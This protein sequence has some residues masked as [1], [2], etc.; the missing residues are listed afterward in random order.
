MIL[1]CYIK[2]KTQRA[3]KD[4]EYSNTDI[5]EIPYRSLT[6]QNSGTQLLVV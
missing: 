2:T 1:F 6:M 5:A 4:F 3:C